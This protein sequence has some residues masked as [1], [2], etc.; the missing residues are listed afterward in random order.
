MTIF[1]DYYLRNALLP[2]VTGFALALGGLITAG[3]VVE[4]IFGLPGLGS[5]LSAA[6]TSNDFLV[7]YG[8]VLFITISVATLDGA[9][10]VAV[11]AARPAHPQFLRS[12]ASMS[13]YCNSH[14]QKCG[15]P[16]GS[17][18]ILRYLRRNRSLAIGM[19]IICSGW[20]LFTV[21]RPADHRRQSSLPAGGE[22]QAAAEPAV[23]VRHRLLR[24]RPAGRDGAWACGR[25]R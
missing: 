12:E 18:L 4:G 22:A 1:R 17:R 20:W 25:R 21:D 13:D 2:Q 19:L 10:R 24:A 15:S 6:I 8:I 3:A 14:S 16:A 9:G 5:V 7:I 23:S 11:P